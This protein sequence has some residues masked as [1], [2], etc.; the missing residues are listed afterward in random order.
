MCF[1]SL[2]RR[3]FNSTGEGFIFPL[4]VHA[5]VACFDPRLL[6]SV[7]G[8]CSPPLCAC[9][10]H[11]PLA[12]PLSACCRVSQPKHNQLD[13]WQPLCTCNI[14]VPVMKSAPAP[15]GELCRVFW[16]GEQ[17]DLPLYKRAAPLGL[18]HRRMR[19]LLLGGKGWL[20]VF[21]KKEKKIFHHRHPRRSRELLLQL[22]FA[23]LFLLM[24]N[25][26]MPPPWAPRA[27][28]INHMCH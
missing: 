2:L 25:V 22:L 17:P 10:L 15:E 20:I 26:K 8:E 1:F 6:T 11:P 4:D 21:K 23:F 28:N 18:N 27:P 24:V 9:P 5:V 12:R 14:I 16:H 19:R 13:H 7:S 3:S